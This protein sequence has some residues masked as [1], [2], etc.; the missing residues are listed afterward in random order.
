[1]FIILRWIL[2]AGSLFFS[3]RLLNGNILREEKRNDSIRF[4]LNN[5]VLTKNDTVLAKR[6]TFEKLKGQTAPPP[7][8]N[9]SFCR[10]KSDRHFYFPGSHS[11]VL[12]KK[13]SQY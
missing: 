3:M 8:N 1:M 4:V 6:Y 11:S 9:C 2:R 5:K 13:Y 10:S 7:L 12:I